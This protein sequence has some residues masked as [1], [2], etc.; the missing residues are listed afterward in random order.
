MSPVPVPLR[1]GG[2]NDPFAARRGPEAH[3][4][5]FFDPPLLKYL[6]AGFLEMNYLHLNYDHNFHIVLSPPR[7]IVI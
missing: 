3:S 4:I 5:W 2:L 7:K 6:Y 1:T